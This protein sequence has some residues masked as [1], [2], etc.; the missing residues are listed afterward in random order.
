MSQFKRVESF[1]DIWAPLAA[2]DSGPSDRVQLAE[3]IRTCRTSSG[4][5]SGPVPVRL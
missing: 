4:R 1:P 2:A 5:R 3:V